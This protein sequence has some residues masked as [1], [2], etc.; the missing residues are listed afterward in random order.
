MKNSNTFHQFLQSAQR[1]LFRRHYLNIPL[2]YHNTIFY[3]NFVNMN[4][5]RF[6]TFILI[7]LLLQNNLKLSAQTYYYPSNDIN[8]TLTIKEPFRPINYNE[9]SQN[10]NN[11]L[12]EEAARRDALKRYYDQIYFETR[13]SISTNTYLTDDSNL[14]QKILLLQ[15]ATLENLYHLNNSLKAGLLKPENY[16]SSLRTC[17]YNY[18]N[19][20][21][22]FLNL[23]RFK[24]LKL[25]EYQNDSLRNVFNNDFN[26]I[27]TSIDK[28]YVSTYSTEFT[29]IGFA[30]SISASEKKSID[31][32]Y[33]FITN[34]CEGNLALYQKN[35]QE[36][37]LIQ[38]Q[39]AYTVKSFNNQWIKMVSEIMDS[40]A[41]K[42]Q[43][44]DK[45]EK[46]KYLKNER[47][48][49]DDKLGKDFMNYHFGKGGKF[50]YAIDD[51]GRKF[52]NY[53]QN[54][55]EKVSQWSNFNLFYK[56]ISEFCNCGN[57]NSK[58][59]Y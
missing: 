58:L 4:I 31:K 12:Q 38:Q 30:E 14:N 7:I 41:S 54:S 47:K 42:W 57:Y 20:N 56:Y 25:A 44:L 55:T 36:Q 48:Y 9:L 51:S 5:M 18:I 46:L 53:A 32:L 27:L 37:K 49:L 45:K 8:I 23:A 40:R 52:I 26:T 11:A 19:N 59:F 6:T 29:V 3:T 24:Y 39:E 50:K 34:A 10:F 1:L 22:I 2:S 16:E 43:K 17:Y 28:I 35:W 15:N 21:Q 33:M 13:S